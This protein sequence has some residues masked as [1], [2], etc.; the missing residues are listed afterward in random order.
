VERRSSRIFLIIFVTLAIGAIVVGAELLLQVV[1]LRWGLVPV[2]LQL[3]TVI[4]T[5]QVMW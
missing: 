5:G 2:L 1:E 4:V 3:A